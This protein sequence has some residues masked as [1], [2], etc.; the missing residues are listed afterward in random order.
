M[1]LSADMTCRQPVIHTTMKPH[2]L[3]QDY[4]LVYLPVSQFKRQ[5]INYYKHVK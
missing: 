3:V 2:F 5:K 1:A 4:H